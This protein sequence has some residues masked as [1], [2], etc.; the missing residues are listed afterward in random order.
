MSETKT[1]NV[2]DNVQEVA[3][4]SQKVTNESPDVSSYIAESK[5]YRSRAQEA[6]SRLAELEK[7]LEDNRNA[8]LAKKEEW[9]TLYQ[10]AKTE[11]DQMRPKLEYYK[12]Q[13]DKAVEK[14]LSDFPEEKREVFKGMSRP[15]LEVVHS[16]L[17]SKPSQ[18]SVD[19]S[20]PTNNGGYK[21]MAEWAALDPKG[22]EKANNAQTSGEI[23]IAYG[24]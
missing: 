5:K 15:Q 18:V 21:D 16:E 17:F 19:N 2:Q 22:Y 12:A 23:K 11:N 3:T 8:N 14:M 7:K 10:E 20:Q 9:K 13:D 4:E 1:E 6:E 24:D